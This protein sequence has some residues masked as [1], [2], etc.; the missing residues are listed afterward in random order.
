MKIAIL[1]GGVFP[2]LSKTFIIDQITELI[3]RGHEVNIYATEPDSQNTVHPNVEK[4]QLKKHIYYHKVPENSLVRL[5]KLTGIWLANFSKN[6]AVMLRTLNIFKYGKKALS[7][8]LLYLAIPYLDKQPYDVVHCHFGYNGLKG[9]ALRD[10]GVLRG[11]LI[12]TFHGVSMSKDLQEKGVQIYNR[13]FEKGDLF[14]PISEHWQHKLIKL[15]CDESKIIVHRMGIDCHNFAFMPRQPSADGVTRL[16]SISRLV[17]KKGIEYGIRAVAKL[18]KIKPDLEYNIVGDGLLKPKLQEL[19]QELNVGNLVKL[20]GWKQKTE[21]IDI[22]NN[23]HV[24]LAPSI[25][26]KNGDREGIPVALMEAMAMGLP[27]ISSLHSGIPEL[28]A[29]GISGFLIPERDVEGIAA[30]LNYL[31]EHP[32]MWPR[33]GKAGREIVEANYDID[34][35]NHRLLEIYQ[36][37]CRDE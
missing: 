15:G 22:L 32:E 2:T 13:L 1:A 10:L 27:V 23:S 25:T 26:A 8:R 4:Y 34:K 3:D 5:R 12:V 6:P 7:L 31:I 16:V 33:M 36:E 37:L 28:V 24:L 11:K 20:L 9:Q 30:K 19:I 21:V 14:L 17:E 35:L 18:A 29:D